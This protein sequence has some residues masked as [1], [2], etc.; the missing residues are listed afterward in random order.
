LANL[1]KI[2]SL[3]D[4][5]HTARRR[6]PKSV[7][8]FVAGGAEDGRSLRAN[9]AAFDDYAF[10]PRVLVDVSGRSQAITLFGAR[11]ASPFGIPP[12][13]ASALCRFEA[14]LA[15]ARAATA[16]NVPF[17]LSGPSTVP[18]ERVI[19]EAPGAWYQ[20]YLPAGR[21]RIGRLLDRVGAAGY[22]VL[23][24]TLDVPVGANRENNLRNGFS[25]PVRPNLRLA[26]DGLLHPRWLA[27]TLVKTLLRSG[28]PRFENF[29]AE[30]GGWIISTPPG[31]QHA[32]RDALTWLD[33]AW[34]RDQWKGKLVLKGILG[35][36]DARRACGEGIDGIIVSNHGGRQLDGAVA[37]LRAL[38]AV[39]EAAG[40]TVI[41]MDGGI[42][43]G[44]DVLKALALGAKCVFAGRPLLFGAAVAG[45]AG[46]RHAIAILRQEIDRDLA[47]LGC[48]DIASVSRDLLVD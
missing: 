47:L 33:L 1:R 16:E 22:E 42:R 39:V 37:P 36:D 38:P 43:R 28:I 23:V 24:V 15:L 7:F 45:E 18:L 27:G 12:M 11:Y 14:D 20:A 4:F 34:I 17:I 25:M 6:L 32:G 40:E 10:R 5:E 48:A 3:Q 31:G 8:G 30:R 2:L 41:M 19:R 44:T 13:G 29:A 46:V 26:L 9:R 35:V 21:E